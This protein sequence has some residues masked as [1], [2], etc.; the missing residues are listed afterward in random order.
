MNNVIFL[1][2][3]PFFYAVLTS[4]K[5]LNTLF[6]ISITKGRKLQP[7]TLLESKL[8]VRRAFESPQEG[9]CWFQLAVCCFTLWVLELVIP[10]MKRVWGALFCGSHC[11]IS[12]YDSFVPSERWLPHSK[13]LFS[14]WGV[15]DIPHLLGLS[16]IPVKRD[17]KWP[18]R[19]N[20]MASLRTIRG[21]NEPEIKVWTEKEKWIHNLG[22]G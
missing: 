20:V 19:A 17:R 6:I 12:L 2:E 7:Y 3:L 10:R 18:E 9:A 14:L 16:Q 5:I 11:A 15:A 13:S 22:Q 4:P 8:H 1:S 21:R